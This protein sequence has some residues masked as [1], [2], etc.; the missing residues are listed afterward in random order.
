MIHVKNL[1]Y[2]YPK[3][4]ELTIRNISF[5]IERGE[6]FGFLGPSGAG[7][8]TTQ[9]ILTRIIRNYK[10][11][12]RLE[13]KDLSSWGSD[14]YNH[15]GVGFELPNH[16]AK[17]TALENM[18]FFSAFYTRPVQPLM[19]LFEMVGLEKDANKKTE[20]YSKGMK[21][22][23]NFIRAIMHNPNVLFLDEPT[24]GLDPAN[25]RR[26]KDII[27]DLKNQG[28]TIFL[29]THNM[30]DAEELCDRVSF[31]A[32]GELKMT[33]SP[34]NLKLINGER[35]VKIDYGTNIIKSVEF[36]LDKLGENEEFLMLI[37]KEKIISI[38]SKEAELDDVF[39][40]ITGFNLN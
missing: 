38:H 8:S 17:L 25:A 23:L 20:N 19:K 1:E 18:K 24:A 39:I 16:Y 22:R 31:I 35:S 6:I 10:G 33:E 11:E 26:I 32:N 13:N 21:M 30:H 29:T 4:E 15:I 14:Y 34:R 37:R 12:V 5:D 36:P 28:K 27:L 9:K 7:K 40:K 2:T 3:A